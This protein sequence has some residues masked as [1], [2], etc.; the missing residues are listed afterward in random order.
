MTLELLNEKVFLNRFQNNTTGCH[1]YECFI[2]K[3]KLTYRKLTFAPKLRNIRRRTDVFF[4]FTSTNAL[5]PT[6]LNQLIKSVRLLQ[7][8]MQ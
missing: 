4:K 3:I 1:Y 8:F 7:S 2:L 6:I 5:T